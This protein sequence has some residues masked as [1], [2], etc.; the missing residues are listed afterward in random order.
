MS[1]IKTKIISQTVNVQTGT[2][3]KTTK[4]KE[5]AGKVGSLF[6]YLFSRKGCLNSGTTNL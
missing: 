2:G 3:F 6:T 4:K 1:A 5:A